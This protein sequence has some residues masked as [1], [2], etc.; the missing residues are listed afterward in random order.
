MT[1]AMDNIMASKADT[2]TCSNNYR[3]LEQIPSVRF[4]HKVIFIFIS[5]ISTLL[6]DL[7]LIFFYFLHYKGVWIHIEGESSPQ[8]DSNG[9][10]TGTDHGGTLINDMRD[11]LKAAQ[12]HNIFVFPTLWNGAVNQNYHY[13]LNG[14]IKVKSNF[15]ILLCYKN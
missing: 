11:M 14:L 15:L 6:M 5:V 4:R 8:F 13:R 7:D 9:H 12:Q 3:P 1:L 10:V 2:S